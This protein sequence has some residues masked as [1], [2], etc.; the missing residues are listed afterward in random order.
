M[1]LKL[2]STLSLL[3][4]M[5]ALFGYSNSQDREA[6]EHHLITWNM[7]GAAGGLS[8][9]T[10]WDRLGGIMAR[11]S[12]RELPVFVAAIQESGA[13]P[14]G[15]AIPTSSRRLPRTTRW[16][17]TTHGRDWP[18]EYTWTVGT[19][20]RGTTPGRGQVFY[21]YHCEIETNAGNSGTGQR[22][23]LAIVSRQRADELIIMRTRREEPRPLLCIRIGRQFFCSIHGSAQNR[24]AVMD[25]VQLIETNIHNRRTVDGH[26]YS[27]VILGDYNRTP[28]SMQ[29]DNGLPAIGNGMNRL[30]VA[31]TQNTIGGSNPR[32]IDF[33]VVGTTD[34]DIPD[35]WASTEQFLQ[36]DHFGVR[37]IPTRIGNTVFRGGGSNFNRVRGTRIITTT[38]PATWQQV[39]EV[40]RPFF[41]SG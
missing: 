35:I 38:T 30:I 16:G 27:W 8:Y 28:Q 29:G 10:K 41:E 32:V 31:P 11:S 12:Q 2:V 4:Y 1:G 18:T 5:S 33:M 19:S 22:T 9:G 34:S 14:P 36:S 7:Q 40:D 20:Q 24:N 15:T 13:P 21:I 25:T 37:F 17:S 23:N 3:L 6:F 26:F 39:N